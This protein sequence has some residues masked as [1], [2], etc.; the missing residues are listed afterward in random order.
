MECKDIQK[1][2]SPFIDNELGAQ[3]TFTV[4]EHIETCPSCLHEMDE[5]R[6]LDEQLKRAGHTPVDGIEELRARILDSISP[7]TWIRRWRVVGVAAAVL[8]S[9]V[10]GRQL[11]SAPSDPETA[12]FSEALITEVQLSSNQPF[13]LTWLDPH[14]LSDV[15]RQEG[16][17]DVPNLAPAGFH[18]EGARLCSPLSHLFLQLVYRNRNEEVSLFVSKRWTRPF[19]GVVKRQGFTIVPLGIRAVYLVTRESLVNF[20]DMRQLAQE[21]IDA[22]ST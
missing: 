21:E 7:V 14:S 19:S 12:A 10:V 9:L 22:L 15:L 18:L 13:S 3:D 20:V 6:D 8:F 4:A 16:L 2:L 1:L 17:E 5:I 11:F